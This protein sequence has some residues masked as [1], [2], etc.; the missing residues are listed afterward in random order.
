[1]EE[2]RHP[3]C[4]ELLEAIHALVDG[5][6]EGREE[7][8]RHLEE[9]LPCRGYLDSARATRRALGALGETE[10]CTAEERA[11]IEACLGEVLRRV[12]G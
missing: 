8:L 1:M 2:G 9:C 4:G 11:D 7:L 5:E 6:G 12:R 10:A 3:G